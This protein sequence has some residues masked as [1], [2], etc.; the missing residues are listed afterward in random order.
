MYYVKYI[1]IYIYI[2]SNCIPFYP[3]ISQEMHSYPMISSTYFAPLGVGHPAAAASG[4]TQNVD[5][6]PAESQLSRVQYPPV[7][8]KRGWVGNTKKNGELRNDDWNRMEFM[9][10]LKRKGTAF[11]Q[12]M[13]SYPQCQNEWTY[14]ISRCLHL[15]SAFISAPKAFRSHQY[16]LLPTSV[17]PVTKAW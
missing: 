5:R 11:L 13:I 7:R 8:I 6:S 9:N 10:A 12:H 17:M 14:E 15:A 3:R 1:Y 16:Y 2:S 4:G